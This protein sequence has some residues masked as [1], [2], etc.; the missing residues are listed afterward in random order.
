MK[1]LNHTVTISGYTLRCLDVPLCLC[2]WH[3]PTKI[4]SAAL[5]IMC[6]SFSHSNR[7]NQISRRPPAQDP[8]LFAW[9]LGHDF[10]SLSVT[11][12]T[13]H[14]VLAFH[15]PLTPMCGISYCYFLS[16]SL[17][18]LEGSAG[19]EL[20]WAAKQETL[21]QHRVCERSSK[22]STSP[23]HWP[24]HT[25]VEYKLTYWINIIGTWFIDYTPSEDRPSTEMRFITHHIT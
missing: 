18:P 1:S 14:P 15:E 19:V 2:T 24:S 13:L 7:P 25:G 10:L 21:T 16:S 4:T 23:Q 20:L 8:A 5:S 6:Q 22:D 11:S 9:A 17:L 3:A 12:S